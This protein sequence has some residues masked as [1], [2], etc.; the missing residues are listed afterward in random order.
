MPQRSRRAR[1]LRRGCSRRRE[2][3]GARVN[4]ERTLEPTATRPNRLLKRALPLVLL[5]LLALGGVAVRAVFVGAQANVT[6]EVHGVRL[7]LTA[8]QVRTQFAPG[9]AGRWRSSVEEGAPVLEWTAEGAAGAGP[10]RVRFEFHDGLLVALRAT[11][12]RADALARGERLQVTDGSV[13]LREDQ[14]ATGVQLTLIARE[15]PT[16]AAEVQRLLRTR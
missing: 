5:V 12:A 4:G 3:Y 2:C 15:C 13:L 1:V 10:S 6:A 11:V 8:G 9:T 16:H 14:G 7:G